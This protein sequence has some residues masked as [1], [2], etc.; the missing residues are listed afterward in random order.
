M[1]GGIGFLRGALQRHAEVPTICRVVFHYRSEARFAD[2]RLTREPRNL[3]FATFS[4]LPEPLQD[5]DFL[6]ARDKWCNRW[7]PGAPGTRNPS[8]RAQHLPDR[9]GHVD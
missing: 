1:K 2:A 8:P 9:L 7:Q 5:S 4:L 3:P 6:L